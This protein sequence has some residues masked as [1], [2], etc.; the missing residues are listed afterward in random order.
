[1]TIAR[2]K[3]M[4]VPGIGP[5]VV[6]EILRPREAL[7]LAL[8]GDF[9]TLTTRARAQDDVD[10]QRAAV[11]ALLAVPPPSLASVLPKAGTPPAREL[12]NLL[13]KLGVHSR[14]EA[15]TLALK[16]GLL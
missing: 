10:A 14:L 9:E 5:C 6:C 8:Q 16:N 7:S 12:V 15:V 3:T 4:D 2:R 11:A 13:A 1:M